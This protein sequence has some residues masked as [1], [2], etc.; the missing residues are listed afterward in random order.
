[1]FEADLACREC[2]DVEP[3]ELQYAGRLLASTKCLT[4][5][6]TIKHDDAALRRAYLRDLERRV[7]TKPARMAK[8]VVHHPAKY[9]T[10]LPYAILTKPARL[11]GEA[12]PL[13]DGLLGARDR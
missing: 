4:C 12:K 10:H 11:L 7:R 8:R 1:V 2:G 9:V 3:H 5:G 6:A 13:I